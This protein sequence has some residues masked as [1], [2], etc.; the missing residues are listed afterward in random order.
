MAQREWAKKPRWR[1]RL[2]RLVL[3]ALVAF[4]GLNALA[5]LHARALTV[6]ADGGEKTRPPDQLGVLELVKVGLVGARLPH[7]RPTKTPAD[8]GLAYKS[9]MT[10]T[11][12]GQRI[13][14][15]RIPGPPGSD[16]IVLAPGYG[17]SV[18]EFL[19]EARFFNE[20]G[21]GVELLSFRGC[22]GS[23]GEGTSIGYHEAQDAAALYRRLREENPGRRLVFYG[24]SMGAAAFLGAIARL[25]M[26]PDALI[27]ECPFDRLITTI[28]NRFRQAGAPSWPLA[29]L[30]VFW[31][32][33]LQGYDGFDHEP[34]DEAAAVACPTLFLHGGQDL[35]VTRAEARSIYERIPARKRWHCFEDLGH[36]PYYPE[37]EAEWEAVLGRFFEAELKR[38]LKTR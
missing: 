13:E 7:P 4:L 23:S 16:I 29:D 37:A 18:E 19:P 36:K 28:R 35:N 5:L 33:V 21:L 26:A 22:A 11:A 8:L 30:L 10:P 34:I 14:S 6:Y 12:D 2:R 38:P 20:R 3:A 27:L 25:D 32:G 15:W 9:R 1:P 17:M 31:G 24:R